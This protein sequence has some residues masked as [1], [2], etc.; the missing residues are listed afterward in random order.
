[1]LRRDYMLRMIEEFM[2]ALSRMKAL[3]RGE[4]WQEA[5]GAAEEEFQKLL[6]SDAKAIVKMSETELLARIVQGAPTQAVREKTLMI[7]TLLN[8]AGDIATAQDRHADAQA[9]YLKGLNLLLNVL[10]NDEPFEA[11]SYVPKVDVFVDRLRD[12]SLPPATQ[13]ALMRHH[14]TT[15]AFGK[16]EDI[17]FSMLDDDSA[18]ASLVEF[19]EAFYRRLAAHSD[20]SL[21][22]GN[23]PR[24]ELEA[25]LAE[26]ETRK[27]AFLPS[28]A[29]K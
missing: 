5:S 21:A 4:N 11:P 26:I 1:M 17:F 18:N 10:G 24:A 25:S 15:G 3:K 14:E 28:P 27:A 16:A 12:V 8:E 23:L 29:R 19:G 13:V 9:C 20:I 2:Q 7:A 6:G 22:E